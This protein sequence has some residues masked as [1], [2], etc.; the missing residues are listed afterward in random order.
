MWGSRYP[1]VWLLDPSC[2]LA[3]AE[4]TL[5]LSHIWLQ[6]MLFCYWR[7]YKADSVYWVCWVVT[8][9]SSVGLVSKHLLFGREDL[10]W[11]CQCKSY[12]VAYLLNS[13]W[14]QLPLYSQ[15]SAP[16]SGCAFVRLLGSS[17]YWVRRQAELTWLLC[18][19]SCVHLGEA[20]A[21][22][23]VRSQGAAL[24]IISVYF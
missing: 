24:F 19:V 20:L 17:H 14:L 1:A 6:A 10:L 13:Q 4:F 15:C 23:F 16:E 2:S 22:Y 21:C 11:S 8:S 9:V 5:C 7:V 12:C 18:L 3:L